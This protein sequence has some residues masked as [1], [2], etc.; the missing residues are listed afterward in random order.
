MMGE[1]WLLKLSKFES[2][3]ETKTCQSYWPGAQAPAT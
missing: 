2:S 1:D 3:P